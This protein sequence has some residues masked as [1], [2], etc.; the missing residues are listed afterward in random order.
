M[1]INIYN[2][3]KYSIIYAL[4]V[5]G[6]S[7]LSE[8]VTAKLNTDKNIHP[9]QE[10]S[11]H[12]DKTLESLKQELKKEYI[13]KFKQ[14]QAEEEYIQEEQEHEYNMENFENYDTLVSDNEK[15]IMSEL[16]DKLSKNEFLENS[17]VSFG[18]KP[19]NHSVKDLVTYVNRDR[20]YTKKPR[21]IR[22]ID[23]PTVNIP[24][25][26]F[27]IVNDRYKMKPGQ[28]KQKIKSLSD[29][30]EGHTPP[31]FIFKDKPELRHAF[32]N[33]KYNPDNYKI[34]PMD[35]SNLFYNVS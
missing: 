34:K 10:Y 14:V 22:L 17:L 27:Y 5:L 30:H 33:D 11:K 2:V 8:W 29:G 26:Q 9:I 13:K 35:D 32:Y 1:Q 4:F 7:I 19:L 15:Q 6:I 16:N 3:I 25:N 21:K 28:S 18:R 24:G 23:P 20:N 12:L 31:R